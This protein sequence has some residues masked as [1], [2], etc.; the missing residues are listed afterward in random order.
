MKKALGKKELLFCAYVRAGVTPR[1]A[2]AKSGYLFSEKSAVALMERED[3]RREIKKKAAKRNGE[4]SSLSGY[5]RLAYGCCAD[6][7]WLLFC[8]E[9]TRED[10]EKLDLFGVSEIKRPKGGGL[11]IKFFDRYKALER[12]DCLSNKDETEEREF[13]AAIEK[14]AEAVSSV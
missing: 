6:A 9:P 11:E 7:V 3:I 12:L 14:S 10:I 8:E 4:I 1:E 13:Y 5:N 2:A